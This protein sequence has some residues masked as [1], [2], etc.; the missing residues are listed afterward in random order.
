[1]KKYDII[2]D[3][4]STSWMLEKRGVITDQIQTFILEWQEEFQR[5]PAVDSVVMGLNVY[6]LLKLCGKYDHGFEHIEFY[7]VVLPCS[8]NWTVNPN[9]LEINLK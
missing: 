3:F 7:G 4:K 8:N 6:E 2:F 1:M 5:K 9:Y